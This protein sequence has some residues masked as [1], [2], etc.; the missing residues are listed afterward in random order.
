VLALA[1]LGAWPAAARAQNVTAPEGRVVREIRV[2]PVRRPETGD[3]VRR[4]L[5]TRV[6][7]RF[8]AGRLIEDRRRLDALRLFSAIDIQPLADGDGVLV[9]VRVSETLK[10]LPL[11]AFSVTDEN[12]VSAGPGFKGINLFGRGVLSSGTVKFGGATSLSLSLDRPTIT[13]GAW[14]FL[15]Q[16]D[17]QSR[18]NELFAFDE[19]STNVFGK[20][21]WNK[22]SRVQL[23]GRIDLSWVDTNGSDI[24]LSPDG[25]DRLPSVGAF[26][27][28]NSQDSMTNPTD[29][30]FAQADLQRQ[31]GDASTWIL[32]LDGR[33]FQPIGRRSTLSIAAFST[34]QSGE[35]GVGVPEYYQ[36][37][38][39]GENSVRG[40]SLGSRTGKNQ[41]I[42]TLEYQYAIV[43][44]RPFTVFGVNLY[45]GLQL[46]A[47]SDVGVA[48]TD[49]FA[50]SDAI[51]GYGIGVRVLFPF[52]DVMRFDLAFGEPGRGTV[53]AV[54][55]SLKADSQKDRVR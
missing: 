5:S 25:T 12:G 1:E 44:V 55:V 53:F 15:A 31:F 54:G 10:L 17:H 9:D 49:H 4:H 38:L 47:F 41:A 26:V 23:G 28:Y 48:W 34:W 27:A 16:V 14:M 3:L 32:T 21:G 2:G 18:R 50:P 20:A 13:P 42:G 29:G 33:R 46:A 7:E 24:A 35:V 37:G 11:V 36:F 43:P 45:G 51:D 30:W 40:W 6:G 22:S 8:E 19:T 52:I 39:G